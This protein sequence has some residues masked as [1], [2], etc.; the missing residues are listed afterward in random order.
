MKAPNNYKGDVLFMK[1]VVERFIRYAK[2]DTQSD[3]DSKTIPSTKRQFNLA[4]LLVEE[5]KDM[6]LKDV[7]VDEKC[8]VMAT[9]PSNIKK[10]VPT[11]GFLAHIDTTPDMTGKNVKPQ[12][13]E[14]YD[15]GDIVLNKEK[16]IIMSPKVFPELK[17]YVG[18][19]LITTDGTT[20]LGVDD[21]AGVAEIV[22]AMEYLLK[23]PEIKHGTVK[24]AFTPDEEIGLRGM[25]DFDAEKFGADFAYTLDGYA[26]GVFSYETFNA[27][28]AKIT[29]NGIS[30]HPG[31]AK[32]KMINSIELVSELNSML[33]VDQRPQNTE[34]YEGYFHL[35]LINGNVE[36]TV[37]QYIIRDHNK[38][39]LED[40]KELL[41]DAVAFMNR[42]YG[43]NTIQLDLKDQYYNLKYKVEPAMHLVDNALEAIKDAGLTPE[44]VP[45]R[46]GTDGVTLS[47][48]GVPCPNL[49]TG[50]HN[51]HG[52]FE[53]VPTFAMEKAAEVVVGIIEKYGK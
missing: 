23:H 40:R 49:F 33:P 5:L 37:A 20:L 53:Y 19:T 35:Y 11:I 2:I 42:K 31:S 1:N 15:G 50:G 51:F 14:D 48:K 24:V 34:G 10:D 32:N 21:K 30:V 47:Y 45:M 36:Q 25:D 18:K 28:E 46:G 9:L 16:N 27:A 52:K 26:A 7:S 8:V 39:K 12:I 38:E 4:N 13:V 6:G 17:N 44:I 29:V 41:K 3:P 43:E 22:T